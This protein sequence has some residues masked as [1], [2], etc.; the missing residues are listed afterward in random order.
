MPPTSPEDL[1]IDDE[2]T[3]KTGASNL[4]WP[5]LLKI[6]KE[7]PPIAL[8]LSSTVKLLVTI[9]TIAASRKLFVTDVK[10]GFTLATEENHYLADAIKIQGGLTL[11]RSGNTATLSWSEPSLGLGYEKAGVFPPFIPYEKQEQFLTELLP[12]LQNHYEVIIQATQIAVLVDLEPKVEF[13]IHRLNQEQLAVT[14]FITY[15]ELPRG[16]I[17]RK[18]RAAESLLIK[19]LRQNFNLGMDQ[20]TMLDAKAAYEFHARMLNT[21][22]ARAIATITS[23]YSEM[24]SFLTDTLGELKDIPA[25]VF[26]SH[27]DE[28]LHLLE[29]KQAGKLTGSSQVLAQKFLTSSSSSKTS[30]QALANSEALTPPVEL[31]LNASLWNQLRDYQKQGVVWMNEHAKKN[32]GCIL[33]D[34]MGLG[35]TLQTLCVLRTPALIIVPTSLLSNW[36]QEIKRFRPELSHQVYHGGKREYRQDQ[37]I[38]LTTYGVLRSETESE[39]PSPF[40]SLYS[41]VVLDEAHIIRNAETLA[42]SASFKLQAKFK[43]ALTGTPIQN[44]ARDL[45]SLFQ[46]IAPETFSSETSLKKELIEPFLL[47]RTKAQVLTELPPKTYFQHHIEMSSEERKS[48][49]AVWATAKSEVVHRVERGEKL[50]PLT[51]FEVLLRVRQNCDH[52]GLYDPSRIAQASSKLTR[53]MELCEELVEA[54]HSVLV[55]SQWTKFLDRIQTSLLQSHLPF[56]RL[57]GSTQN[58]GA[59]VDSFQNSEHAQVFLLSLHAGGVGL[60]LTRADHVIFCDPWWNPFVELQAEDRA[61]RMGQEKPVTIHRL[62]VEKSI[63]EKLLLLQE[64]KKK[65]AT[66]A[67]GGDAS[68]ITGEQMLGILLE[69]E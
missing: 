15:G 39:G 6:L 69:N 46:F 20:T 10:G 18:D 45:W 2:L 58:R 32:S 61:Y 60:N 23:H 66:L 57:D 31:K 62:I 56:L 17:A 11:E 35:K 64:E 48:Y 40:T 9:G 29:L 37:D 14:P 3:P 26:S 63:E 38:T 68:E 52:V 22:N 8:E 16:K 4:R 51:I 12:K 13:K 24:D 27:R 50:N 33:A 5:A 43:I 44:R 7:L 41:T 1:K 42:A 59:V 36:E 21:S 65:L 25:T 49:E 55:Y 28:I 19:N 67:E 53:L 30:E 34:D 54:G 47:R